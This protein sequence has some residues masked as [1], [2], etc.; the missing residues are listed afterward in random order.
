[1]S[2]TSL[3]YWY[4]Q[5]SRGAKGLG[6]L[7]GGSAGAL[8]KAKAKGRLAAGGRAGGPAGNP[9]AGTR[10]TGGR[11]AGGQARSGAGGGLLTSTATT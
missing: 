4:L 6:T 10:Q 5:R 11:R 7:Q 3:A 2:Q 8:L 9:R 1:M